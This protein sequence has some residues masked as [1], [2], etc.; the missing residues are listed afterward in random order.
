MIEIIKKLKNISI[1]KSGRNITYSGFSFILQPSIQIAATPFLLHYLGAERYGEWI[2]IQG[3]L[4]FIAVLD[5]GIAPA[6]TLLI[7]KNNNTKNN[8]EN[9]SIIKNTW[10]IYLILGLM[11]YI[12]IYY[13][14]DCIIETY[15]L[16]LG[17]ITSNNS[18]LRFISAIFGI[19][20]IQALLDAILRGLERY[21]IEATLKT[22]SSIVLT[23]TVC[24]IVYRG[25]SLVNM[26]IVQFLSNV[27]F[28]IAT[29]LL[30]SLK[31]FKF[32]WLLPRYETRIIK[33][34]FRFGLFSWIQAFSNILFMQT[35]RLVITATLGV[36]V[37]AYYYTAVQLSQLVHSFLARICS[38]LFPR[39]AS[40][41]MNDLNKRIQLYNKGMLVTTT[42]GVF[43]SSIIYIYSNEIIKLWIGPN[44]PILIG[45]VLRVLCVVT[46][47]NATTVVPH[48][49]GSGIG[50][51]H[52]LAVESLTTGV[53]TFISTISGVKSFGAI[54]AAYAK[55]AIIPIIII[56]RA[57]IF[58]KSFEKIKYSRGL[59]ELFP[60]VVGMSVTI[61]SYY[62]FADMANC[63]E[64]CFF[65]ISTII[66]ASSSTII[67]AYNFYM[68]KY[69]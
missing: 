52:I 37:L 21:D 14:G 63:F 24:T 39:F 48:Y 20:I 22:V 1:S 66:L 25:G 43:A 2:L 41:E 57:I 68:K 10:G 5:M 28:L 54:G 61:L 36:R 13:G 50:A 11:A 59:L 51:F 17:S 7:A 49:L 64:R 4:S 60:V 33:K 26:F 38:F 23:L 34:I 12:V 44:A 9:I 55:L 40:E 32:T 45:E 18:V 58:T 31:Y 15:N 65:S 30:L 46:A 67:L 47:F 42:F 69:V 8:A 3:L 6:T 62:A 56:F 35:D 27:I 16:Q 53:I 29:I 19:Q